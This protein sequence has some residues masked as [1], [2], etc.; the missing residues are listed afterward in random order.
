MTSLS[1]VISCY[2]EEKNLKRGILEEM[3]S[4][5]STQ[6]FPW[7]VIITDDESTDNS[8]HILKKYISTH[9]RFRLYKIKHGGKPAGIWNSVQHARYPIV[10]LTDIDQSTPISEINKLLPYFET[11]YDAVIGSRGSGRQGNTIVRK[12]GATVFLSLR[13]LVLLSHIIDTQCG[14]KALRTDLAKKIL[15]NL[16]FFKDKTKK[17]GWRV[18]AFDVEMLFMAQKWG[19][20]IKEVEV[21]WHN[22]DTSDTKGNSL[23]RYKKESVQ[24]IQEIVRVKLND[25]KGLY[26]QTA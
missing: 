1:V 5:L 21:N 10:L 22:Q 14:F 12:I 16:Q 6:K 11:G 18:S 17:I 20:K 3:N 23:N 8:Y 4:F 15:P 25:L 2:N 9:P 26:D 13:R 19:Y 24:M 7:E